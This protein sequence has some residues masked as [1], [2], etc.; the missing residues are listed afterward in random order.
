[1][2]YYF[3]STL[4][5]SIALFS[6]QS[7]SK[8]ADQLSLENKFDEAAELYQKAANRGDAYA[9]WRLAKAYANGQGVDWDENKS[10]ELLKEAAE[11]GCEEAKSDL[12]FAYIFDW[13]NT[14]KETEKGKKILDN[15]VDKTNNSYVLSRYA[16]LLFNGDGPYDE[17]KEK[18]IRIAKKVENKENPYYLSFMADVY[19]EGTD[20]IDIDAEKGIDY[21]ERA[22]YN[23]RKYCAYNLQ[24]IYAS[25]YGSVKPDK[26]KRIDWLRKG[27]EG[28]DTDCMIDM[29]LLCLTEDSLYKDIRNPQKAIELLKRASKKGNGAAYYSIGNLYY[30]GEYLPKDDKKAFENWEMAV[31]LRCYT[32]ASHLAYSYIDGVGCEKDENKG[33]ELHKLAVEH[34]SG[35]SANKLFYCYWTGSW[36]VK[37]DKNLAK[38]YLI[39]SAELNDP[40]GCYN[41]GRQY[42]MGN[43]LMN[44]DNS[45]AFVYIKKAADMGLVDACMGV[46]YLYETGQGVEKDLQKAKEYRDRAAAN[47]EKEDKNQL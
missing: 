11:K 23:G 3:L 38:K 22:F 14:G 24:S 21:L 5:L 39:K 18:A 25:G 12:A 1:M 35:F 29:A 15:L 10:F 34:G 4:V 43:D 33:V 32:A 30:Y 27:I 19:L 13:F 17:N 2:K 7:E 6:C 40:W 36:G 44:K 47:D 41:L 42:F 37:K 45:Q 20:K 9:T 16:S 28:E 26:S 46:A 8:K 31:K